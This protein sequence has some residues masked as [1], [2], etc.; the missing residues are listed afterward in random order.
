[1]KKYSFDIRCDN[2]D[3]PK[4]VKE[5]LKTL[6]ITDFEDVTYSVSS[7]GLPSVI[8]THNVIVYTDISSGQSGQKGE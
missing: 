4:M 5:K 8:K 6:G 3:I 2:F 7:I 1:M